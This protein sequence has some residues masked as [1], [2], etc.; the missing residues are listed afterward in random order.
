[1]KISGVGRCLDEALYI[2]F[3]SEDYIDEQLSYIRE[4]L[5][6][7]CKCPDKR[8]KVNRLWRWA[9]RVNGG[10]VANAEHYLDE[11]LEFEGT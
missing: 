10:D 5:G 11:I 3:G 4:W 7:P 1:M 8:E 2:V 6:K 9:K